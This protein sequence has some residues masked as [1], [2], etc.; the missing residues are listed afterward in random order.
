MLSPV[1]IAVHQ[2]YSFCVVNYNQVVVGKD[3][4]KHG[5]HNMSMSAM[6]TTVWYY[7]LYNNNKIFYYSIIIVYIVVV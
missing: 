4:P 2:A 7:S 1:L 6:S 5:G 3:H